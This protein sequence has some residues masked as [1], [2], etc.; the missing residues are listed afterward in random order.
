MRASR[1]KGLTGSLNAKA[2]HAAPKFGGKSHQNTRSY[3]HSG[4]SSDPRTCLMVGP[5]GQATGGARICTKGLYGGGTCPSER[6]QVVLECLP[7]V[8]ATAEGPFNNQ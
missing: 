7:K 4:F 8:T 5:C 6:S 1:D 2:G 3:H